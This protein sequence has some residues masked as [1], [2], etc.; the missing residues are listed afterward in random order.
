MIPGV[1][2]DEEERDEEDNISHHWIAY[3]ENETIDGQIIEAVGTI[4]YYLCR[5][6][7]KI[8]RLCVLDSYRGLGI[9]KELLLNCESFCKENEIKHSYLDAQLDKKDWYQKLGYFVQDPL[10]PPFLDANIL[11]IRM[12]KAL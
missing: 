4:R 9:G 12:T 5:N 8:G 2:S 1:I 10:A 11:H 7:A 3:D 6:K